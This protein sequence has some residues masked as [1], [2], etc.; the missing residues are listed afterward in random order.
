MTVAS[1][2]VLAGLGMM[3]GGGGILAID[4]F[5]RD[6]DGFLSSPTEEF[7]TEGY[8]VTAEDIDLSTDPAG[9]VPEE[10]LGTTRITAEGSTAQHIFVG[11]GQSADVDTYLNRVAHSELDEV[12][13][14]TPTY[15]EREGSRRPGPP[16]RSDIWVASSTGD[17]PRILD[18]DAESGIWSV[19]VMNEDGGAGVAFDAKAGARLDWL[20]WAGLGLLLLGLVITVSGGIAIY[21][22]VGREPRV[23]P[24]QR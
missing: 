5:A 8:A 10:L 7:E 16:A 19:V 3:I 4:T 2:A 14:G 23:G 21:F 24:A 9:W 6:D 12:E 20:T 17:G 22:L 18:W 13:N 15:L 1:L 11:I